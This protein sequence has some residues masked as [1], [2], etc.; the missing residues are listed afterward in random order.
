MARSTYAGWLRQ[1]GHAAV[2][3]MTPEVVVPSEVDTSG[4]RVYAG[5]ASFVFSPDDRNAVARAGANIRI[6]NRTHILVAAPRKPADD[7]GAGPGYGLLVDLHGMEMFAAQQRAV[8]RLRADWRGWMTEVINTKEVGVAHIDAMSRNE[9]ADYMAKLEL[10]SWISKERIA[11][12][13]TEQILAVV[14]C[15]SGKGERT[16]V[17]DL[18]WKQGDWRQRLVVAAPT[19]DEAAA[20]MF[21]VLATFQP[22]DPEYPIAILNRQGLI[23][24][25]G[26]GN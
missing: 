26:Q 15:H 23:E 25:I 8:Q 16:C 1:D 22:A 24:L 21:K 20:A 6:G 14:G 19:G 4:S 9:F 2:A 13:E 11:W 7:A 12:I 5:Y 18:L 10:K 3:A 17:A